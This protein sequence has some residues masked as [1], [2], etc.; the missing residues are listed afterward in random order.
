MVAYR[1]GGRGADGT[2]SRLELREGTCTS[3][4]SR[5]VKE[6]NTKEEAFTDVSVFSK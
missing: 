6:G 1:L 2:R 4:S 5:Y 3:N